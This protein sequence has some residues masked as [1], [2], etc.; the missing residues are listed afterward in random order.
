M[1]KILLML[2]L[3]VFS[4]ALLTLESQAQVTMY[5]SAG[6]TV[7]TGNYNFDTCLASATKYFITPV[8]ALNGYTNGKYRINVSYHPYSGAWTGK[9][10]IQGRCVGSADSSW[11]NCNQVTGTD[12]RNCD[13]LQI[14]TTSTGGGWTF[15][16][17][18]GIIHIEKTGST[19][20]T[21][22]G[23]GVS[24]AGRWTQIRVIIIGTTNPVRIDNVTVVPQTGP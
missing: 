2:M 8:G 3:T 7:T 4:T 14:T 16:S 12:G 19:G 22:N 23:Y 6:Y 17:A 10:I 13:S 5:R 18:P 20:G 1:K 11:Q 21:Q 15:N 24:S 9:I